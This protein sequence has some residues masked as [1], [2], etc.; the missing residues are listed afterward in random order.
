MAGPRGEVVARKM[1]DYCWPAAARVGRDALF[2]EFRY[3]QELERKC[4]VAGKK[5]EVRCISGAKE[6]VF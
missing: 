6:K 4:V 1:I 5:G 2:A 3:C